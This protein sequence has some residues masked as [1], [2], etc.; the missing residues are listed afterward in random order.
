MTYFKKFPLT[1]YEANGNESIVR[2]ILRRAKFVSEYKPYT[3]LFSSHFIRDGETPQTLAKSYYGSVYNHWVI[4]L[5]NEIHNPYFD[6]P[7]TS[8][9][10]ELVCKQKYG[11]DVMYM[12]RHYE[13]DGVVVGEYKEF[14]P[15]VPWVP[16][17]NTFGD[18]LDIISFSFVDYEQR[19]NDDKRVIKIMRPE[20]LGEFLKQF[21]KAINV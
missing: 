12:T 3:D 16:P 4:M 17:E 20:L 15:L 21:Q 14:N 6:W 19:L 9:A 7:L 18:S 8:D 1:V 13:N 5:F 2:D 11:E 10:V